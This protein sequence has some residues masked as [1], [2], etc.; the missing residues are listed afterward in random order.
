VRARAQKVS[1]AETGKAWRWTAEPR[2]ASEDLADHPA[3]SL[4]SLTSA[5]SASAI[6]AVISSVRQ[7]T[8]Q[9]VV[10]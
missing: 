10:H 3:V 6:G 9:F 1:P 7:L 8:I 5:R 2:S 4:I